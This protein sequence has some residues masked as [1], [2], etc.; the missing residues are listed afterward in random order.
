MVYL[1]FLYHNLYKS[2]YATRL[3]NAKVDESVIRSQMMMKSHFITG[4]ICGIMGF[5]VLNVAFN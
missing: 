2:T 3:I 4:I 5:K 1:V